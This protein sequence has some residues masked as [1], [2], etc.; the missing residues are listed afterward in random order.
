MYILN[1]DI[2]EDRQVII[3]QK[4]SGNIYENNATVLHITI[5]EKYSS[6]YKYMDI[7]KDN[8]EKTQTVIST[9]N[10]HILSYPLPDALTGARE[11]TCQL[12]LKNEAEVFKSNLFVL[13][14]SGSI[15]ATQSIENKCADTIEYLM[16]NKADRE[17]LIKQEDKKLEK[18]IFYS[19]RDTQ[20]EINNSKVDKEEG[21]VLIPYEELDKLTKLPKREN[22]DQTLNTMTEEMNSLLADKVDKLEGKGLSSND[23]T[24]NLKNLLENGIVKNIGET[25]DEL[26]LLD[27]CENPGVY[28][29]N[30]YYYDVE[31]KYSFTKLLIV[32]EI[33]NDSIM[34]ISKRLTQYVLNISDKSLKMRYGDYQTV[35]SYSS[36]DEWLENNQGGN[37]AGDSFGEPV[38]IWSDFEMCGYISDENFTTK[39]KDKLYNLYS[40]E[41]INEIKN[42]LDDDISLVSGEL[43]TVRETA[44]SAHDRIDNLS[45]ISDENFTTELKDKLYNLYSREEIDEIKDTLDNDISLVSGELETVRE[46][47]QSAHDRIDNLSQISD[48]NFSM[49]VNALEGDANGESLI[50]SDVSAVESNLEISLSGDMGDF[51]S[52]NVTVRG[53]NILNPNVYL[54]PQTQYG[55]TLKYIPEEDVFCLDG[56]CTTSSLQFITRLPELIKV[57]KNKVYMASVKL[58][59]GTASYP[60]ENEYKVFYIGQGDYEGHRVNFIQGN[61]KGGVNYAYA[62]KHNYLTYVWIY[63]I[64]NGDSFDN[65]KFRIQVSEK[66]LSS[67]YEKWVPQQTTKAQADGTVKGLNS[68]Y[69]TTIIETDADVNIKCNYNRDINKAF[70]ELKQAIISLGGNI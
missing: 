29:Y 60:N 43:E 28:I 21:K 17:E 45:Q 62:P 64:E 8:K 23:F 40:R 22:L 50:L 3:S 32:D 13:S 56:T 35:S 63:N 16:E 5:P 68:V 44:Q 24:D 70:A 12:V 6:Y 49:M 57:D 14:F 2:K 9:K 58:V 20:D 55:V 1:I 10:E 52:V 31:T 38:L 36:L 39:L 69:P 46:T 48:E 19:F 51:S 47:A 66:E 18:N 33:S 59:S 53:R 15:N 30:W 42:T 67:T 4:N 34:P 65:F 54:E 27:S 7:I 26:A 11:L 37:I 25:D 41:E 61:L